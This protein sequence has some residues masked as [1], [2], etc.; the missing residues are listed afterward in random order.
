MPPAKRIFISTLIFCFW[1]LAAF[2][3][4]CHNL[5]DVLIAGQIYFT[6]TDCYSRM[7]RARMVE[8]HPGLIIRHQDFE[9]YPEGTTTHATAPMDYLIVALKWVVAAILR[10]LDRQGTSILEKQ[11]L[12]VAGALTS[13]LLGAAACGF[14]ALY[15]RGLSIAKASWWTVPFV[16]AVSP[17]LVHG[18]V[19]GRP[20][21]QSLQM[22]LLA[23]GIAAECRLAE[24]VSRRWAI[25][26]GISWSLA[27][28][29]S[30]YEP[31]VL[32]GVVLILWLVWNPRGLIARE[33]RWGW[34]AF[35]AI[36]A[37]ALLLEG[38]PVAVPEGPMR[39]YLANWAGTIGEMR[40]LRL[41][42][43][44]F[45]RWFGIA[46]VRPEDVPGNSEFFDVF[47]RWL[48]AGCILAPVFLYRA[49]RH[50]RRALGLGILL[51][52]TSV[53]TWWQ[54]RW[55]YFAAMIFVL[56]LPWQFSV[57]KRW[58]SVPTFVLIC[59]WPTLRAWEKTIYVDP[60]QREKLHHEVY[61]LR[62]TAESLRGPE[63]APFMAPWWISPALAYWSEQP[64]VAGSS[65]ESI[66]GTV[67]SA[68]FYLAA[69][70]Q[71]SAAILRERGVARVVG[72]GDAERVISA[73]AP[74]LGKEE[75]EKCMAHLLGEQ[76]RQPAPFLI[77][78]FS[79]EYFH[80][81]AVD[82]ARLNP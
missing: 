44:S 79:N 38:W 4:R 42:R 8:A 12:D 9:N 22:V 76:F 20:D 60:E 61:L 73:C 32:F 78:A 80:V 53:L 72:D 75:P 40:H 17:I 74:I 35:I 6:D 67:D 37:V 62:E 25:A 19:L 59:A 39:S 50:D 77:P 71:E 14:L 47:Y 58:W 56:S 11:T 3:V 21:H 48:G 26:S 45:N 15:A 57:F 16:W 24:Q 36:L 7:T 43:F 27:L 2:V 52:F 63:R 64:G 82:Q 49:M 65:H 54:I 68:R 46:W 28:W 18:T 34:A 23:L 81:Y 13:P 29:V 69:T 55:G 66:A 5:H 41:G 1:A 51:I 10:I 31:L 30:L 33:R 70:P